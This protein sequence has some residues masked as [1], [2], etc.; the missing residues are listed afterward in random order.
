MSGMADRRRG[1]PLL[2]LVVLLTAWIGGRA[3]MWEAPPGPLEAMLDGVTR[4]VLARGAAPRAAPPLTIATQPE[5]NRPL[6]GPGP[7]PPKQIVLL[8][9]LP[10]WN[11]QAATEPPPPASSEVMA[12]HQLLWLAATAQLPVPSDVA[13]LLR[14]RAAA[15]ASRA[16]PPLAVRKPDRWSFDAWLLLRPGETGEAAPGGRLASY[17]ASQAGAVIRYHLAP[18]SPHRPAAYARATQ[19]LAAGKE[20]EF[21]AGLAARPFAAVPV[22]VY[23]ELRVT[24]HG[25]G[26][27]ELR[28]ATFAVTELPPV[29]LPLG[30]RGEAYAQAGYVGGKFA[31]AFADGQARVDREVAR[32]DLAKVRAGAGVWGGA[33]KGA[34]RL[35]VGPTAS[36][37][38]EIGDA[39]AR[40]ALDYR[41][42][43]AGE[44]APGRGIAVTLSTGF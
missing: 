31:T 17:G 35:D 15:P 30:L 38:L 40:L 42:R 16:R 3:M 13:A 39:P 23:S 8:E 24:R 34:A 37:D 28:P 6:V 26:E 14:A 19:A 21:A 20:S 27:V 9:R 25:G 4:P 43:I 1:E 7:L 11:P 22:S 33:Q 5:S 44:A 32:F 41:W 29:D 10:I 2:I 12:S 36:L 18:G